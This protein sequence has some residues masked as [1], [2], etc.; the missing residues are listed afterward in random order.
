MSADGRR[1]KA[2]R[3]AVVWG[4]LIL[5]SIDPFVQGQRQQSKTIIGGDGS[6]WVLD[7]TTGWT[8]TGK[9]GK[10]IFIESAGNL[11]ELCKQMDDFSAFANGED[12]D[13]L[14]FACDEWAKLQPKTQ[15]ETVPFSR[16]VTRLLLLTPPSTDFARYRGMYLKSN[17][18]S[19]TFDAAIVP[20]DLGYKTSCMIEEDN[21]H[22][23]GMLYT[24]RCAITTASFPDAINL[25][26][27]L[28]KLLGGLSLSE[29]EIREHGLAVNAR[30]DG[31]CAPTGECLE[32]HVYATVMQDWKSLQ[33]DANP[34]FTQN[35]MAEHLAT[36]HG[37]HAAINGI[38]ADSGNVSFR[39]FSVGPNKDDD[40]S[41]GNPATKSYP[42]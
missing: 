3:T 29:D 28:I 14:K 37:Q 31:M 42:R 25:E 13:A 1:N 2:V 7:T 27:H 8:E 19:R 34:A 35:A 15:I 12:G 18:D 10:T 38:D 30:G 4:T 24:Y 5:F 40:A 23:K 9:N 32:E 20:D 39:I 22:A 6:K 41:Q 16:L 21:R 11:I 17:G 26:N 33:I 36:E